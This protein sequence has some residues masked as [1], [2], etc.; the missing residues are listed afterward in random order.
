[1]K[2]IEAANGGSIFLDEIGEMSLALQAKLLRVLEDK[3]IRRVGGTQFHKVNLR[4][5]AATNLDLQK[6]VEAKR[7]REDLFYR[8]NI[9]PIHLAPLRERPEDVTA[10][11]KYFLSEC[12][13][14]FGKEF[15]E[16]SVEAEKILTNYNWPGNVRELRNI[17]ERICIMHDNQ[18]LDVEHLPKELTTE[19]PSEDHRWQFDLPIPWSGIDLEEA[20]DQFSSYLIRKAIKMANGNIS[21]AAKLLGTPRG[22]LRY[23]L[24]K[25][26]LDVGA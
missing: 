19:I 4:I 23:K 14:R 12:G 11:T 15:Q 6:W 22:T 20:V 9:F 3:K 7:F 18:V 10:L 26:D 13:K 24:E 8:L 21:K 2:S 1:L 5:I 16:I 17:I 25:L